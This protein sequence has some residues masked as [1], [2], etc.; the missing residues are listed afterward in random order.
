MKLLCN[1][2]WSAPTKKS[3]ERYVMKVQEISTVQALCDISG[4][5]L[6]RERSQT[7]AVIAQSV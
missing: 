4:L 5:V 1:W 7:R 2:E 6:P 3:E